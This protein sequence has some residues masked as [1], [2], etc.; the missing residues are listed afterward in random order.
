MGKTVEDFGFKIGFGRV[1]FLMEAPKDRLVVTPLICQEVPPLIHHGPELPIEDV[2]AWLYQ[3]G[4]LPRVWS[5]WFTTL[6]P[7]DELAFRKVSALVQKLRH[8]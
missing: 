8:R 6:P 5:Q 3:N 2:K 1:W 4:P 7:E